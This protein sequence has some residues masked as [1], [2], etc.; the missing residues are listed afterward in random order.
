MEDL[1]PLSI[2][3]GPRERLARLWLLSGLV[4]LFLPPSAVFGLLF[5]SRYFQDV[6]FEASLPYFPV[7]L[8]Q[9]RVY[10]VGGRGQKSKKPSSTLGSRISSSTKYGSCRVEEVRH[11]LVAGQ[12]PR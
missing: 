12:K 10:G 3:Q 7:L 5:S 9:S 1:E 11:L 8:P 6:Q 2:V 4:L